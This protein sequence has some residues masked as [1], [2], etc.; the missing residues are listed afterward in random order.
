[1]SM[2]KAEY[3]DQFPTLG[4]CKQSGETGIVTL[5]YL[6]HE[7]PSDLMSDGSFST[8][9]LVCDARIKYGK[10]SRYCAAAIIL[11]GSK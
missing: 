11:D 6:K 4:I 10:F 8:P 7:K 5:M 9:A 2:K 1:M 3:N